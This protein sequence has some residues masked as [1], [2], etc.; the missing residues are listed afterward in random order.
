MVETLITASHEFM[1]ALPP[2][3]QREYF[4]R[5]VNCISDKVGKQ[6]IISATVHMDEKTSHMHL[7]FC[8]IT[9]DN[10]LSAKVILGDRNSLIK[11]QDEYHACMSERWNELERGISASETNR[12]HIPVWLFK[13]AERMDKQFDEVCTA[14][15]DINAFNAGK[16]REIALEILAKWLPE[17]QRFTSQIKTVDKH[18]ESLETAYT[19][20]MNANSRYREK[21]FAFEEKS[22]GAHNQ[23]YHLKKQLE[24]QSKLIERIPEDVLIQLKIK[25]KEREHER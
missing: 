7:S 12:Q 9:K 4:I 5:A 25:K 18:I 8:P 24:R 14:L 6:N 2:N 22:D 3:E 16:K 15:S 1:N 19:T 21:V 23:I 11:W 20:Q 13:K 10:K 17:A